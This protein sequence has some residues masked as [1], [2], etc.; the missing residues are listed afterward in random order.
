MDKLM[1]ESHSAE[2]EEGDDEETNEATEKEAATK[3]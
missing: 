3:Q 1:M 2:K